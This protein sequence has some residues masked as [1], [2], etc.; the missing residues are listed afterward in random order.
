MTSVHNLLL[1][2]IV[3]LRFPCDA[4]L[5]GA[6]D[7]IAREVI[8]A[9]PMTSVQQGSC[10]HQSSAGEGLKLLP[11]HGTMLTRSSRPPT[12]GRPLSAAPLPQID[13]ERRALSRLRF[14]RDPSLVVADYRL[15]DR[16]AQ[17]R[18]V[19]PGGVVRREQ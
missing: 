6:L 5:Q 11:I 18:A 14:H 10:L 12:L 15:H 4:R 3:T 1:R 8:G 19:R 2:K 17:S 16:Q 13:P 9:V 7:C